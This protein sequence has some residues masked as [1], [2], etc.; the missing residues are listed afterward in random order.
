MT[1]IIS[2]AVTDQLDVGSIFRLVA[3]CISSRCFIFCHGEVQSICIPAVA[4]LAHNAC[5]NDSSQAGHLSGEGCSAVCLQKDIGLGDIQDCIGAFLSEFTLNN[6][7]IVS[8]HRLVISNGPELQD[9]L[10][11]VD[12]RNGISQVV[13][14][15]VGNAITDQLHIGCAGG[16]VVASGCIVGSHCKLQVAGRFCT[17]LP[18]VGVSAHHTCIDN[19]GQAGHFSGEACRAVSIQQDIGLA[20]VQGGIGGSLLEFAL[21]HQNIVSQQGLVVHDG[22]EF[23]GVPV[24]VALVDNIL[25]NISHIIG[26]TVTDQL[27]IACIGRCI[28]A[29]GSIVSHLE[30]QSTG[31]AGPTVA[32]HLLQHTAL[33]DG[34]QS[35]HFLGEFCIGSV[36]IDIVLSKTDSCIIGSIVEVAFDDVNIAIHSGSIFAHSPAIDVQIILICVVLH[37]GTAAGNR[38]INGLAVTDTLNDAA[39]SGSILQSPVALVGSIVG[40]LGSHID[41]AGSPVIVGIGM[42]NQSVDLHDFQILLVGNSF[43]VVAVHTLYQSLQALSAL[44]AVVLSDNVGHGAVADSQALAVLG[45][46][47]LDGLVQILGIDAIDL[48]IVLAILGNG[49]ISLI[50]NL[51]G[52]AVHIAAAVEVETDRGLILEQQGHTVQCNTGQVILHIDSR[53]FGRNCSCGCQLVT[54]IGQILSIVAEICLCR[55]TVVQHILNHQLDFFIIA[56]GQN[57]FS[58]LTNAIFAGVQGLITIY[59]AQSDSIGHLSSSHIG[60]YNIVTVF[61]CCGSCSII[62]CD[63]NIHRIIRCFL[64]QVEVDTDVVT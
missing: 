53:N 7:D 35:G 8:N 50:A 17:G 52:V 47:Q 44:S 14:Y 38:H 49:S 57:S 19:G 59:Y 11:I 23:Q 56:A 10:V 64:F 61:G 51:E 40:L 63:S 5:I 9:I 20:D 13:T 55:C 60:S 58:I 32:V 30:N 27:N 42:L 12:L 25:T 45:N 43:Q 29:V 31:A 16:S 54:G 4:V 37:D 33:N 18:A 46:Y 6:Q 34:G 2:C 62:T 22:P 24:V 48:Y 39:G 36:Q 21:N 26:F 1:N 3:D 41:T 15:L 28:A